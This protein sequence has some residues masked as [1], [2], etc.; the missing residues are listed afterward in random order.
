MS[1]HSITDASFDKEVLEAN[2]PVVV[3]FWATWCAPC[4][5]MA[6]V[7]AEAATYYGDQIKFVKIDTDKNPRSSANYG[8][9]SL[10]TLLVFKNG[11]IV[12]AMV[13]ARPPAQ[14]KSMLDRVIRPK[15]FLSRLFGK[16]D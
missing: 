3:D 12:D 5:M 7:L 14:I 13:G 15:G 8:I 6:P 9:R 10:P 4:K 1:V 16:T 2:V 11:E